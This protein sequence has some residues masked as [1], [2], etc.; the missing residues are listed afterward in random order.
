VRNLLRRVASRHGPGRDGHLR[1]Q[2][3]GRAEAN[4]ERV[5][6]GV[7]PNDK[8]GQCVLTLRGH[9]REVYSACFSPDGAKIVSASG[10][11][12]VRAWNAATGECELTLKG[13]RF[14]H[15]VYSACFSPDGAKIVSASGDTT[16]RAWNAATGECELTLKGHSREV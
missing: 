10:D 7:P 11:T 5:S 9:S 3:R 15:E 4:G 12:T 1:E 13:H 16:V 6:E 14:S 8:V 2:A